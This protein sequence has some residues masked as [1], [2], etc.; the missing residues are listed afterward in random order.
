LERYSRWG[1]VP[2]KAGQGLLVEEEDRL[3]GSLQL[4]EQSK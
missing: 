2:E 1:A 4:L 3:G